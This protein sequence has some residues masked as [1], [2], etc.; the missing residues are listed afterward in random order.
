MTTENLSFSQDSIR[1][2]ITDWPQVTEEFLSV[3]PKERLFTREARAV[4]PERALVVL[5]HGLGEHSGRYGHVAAALAARGFS[6]V[7]WDLRGH[8]QSSGNR[9]DVADSEWLVDDLAAVCARFRR[10]ETPLF[11]FAHSLGGQIAL[12]LLERDSGVCRG[13]V[14]ASPWLR[15]AF[16]PP[17]W[18]VMLGRFAMHLW[19]RFAQPTGMR[20]ERLSRDAAHMASF[21][22]KALM[23][24]RISARMYFA[25]RTGGERVLAAA[26]GLRTPLLLLHGDDDPVT[27]HHATG[28]FFERVGSADRTLR[29]FP[30]ARHEM[31]NDLV[32]AEVLREAGDWI[33]ARLAPVVA[34]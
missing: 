4:G 33:E 26:A 27:S 20:L 14:I 5:T 18:K 28:E 8:G 7:G 17:R 29:I 24:Q 34:E 32:R 2:G 30:A 16:D 12:R 11:L 9:G 21:P 23:H 6:V 1:A 25:M 22:D 15:L 13:A 3:A 10:K 19:P 31:H